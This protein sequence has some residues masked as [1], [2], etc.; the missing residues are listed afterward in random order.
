MPGVEVKPSICRI[1][2]VCCP[3]LVEIV[4]GRRA[5][6]TGDRTNAIPGG[7]TCVKGRAHTDL[8][9]H[10]TRLMH[11]MKRRPDGSFEPIPVERAMDEIAERIRSILDQFG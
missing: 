11:S 2:G 9:D 4:D 6:R 10:P 8:Y 1:C 3:V 5:R 7:Y